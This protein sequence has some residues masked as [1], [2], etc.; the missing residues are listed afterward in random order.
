MY[1]LK[2][3]LPIQNQK[4]F[5][6]KIGISQEYLSKIQNEKLDCGKTTAYAITKAFDK[7]LEI[8]DIFERVEE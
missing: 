4:K 8:L 5:A 1:K 2:E 6:K 3:K 7:D